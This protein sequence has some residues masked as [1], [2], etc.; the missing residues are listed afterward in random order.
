MKL[1]PPEN[2]EMNQYS[3]VKDPRNKCKDESL[4]ERQRFHSLP[5]GDRKLQDLF[6]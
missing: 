4:K 2:P 5:D 1:N 6:F 3:N